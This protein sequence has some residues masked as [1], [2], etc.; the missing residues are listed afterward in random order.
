MCG[1]D[2][3]GGVG[4][5]D[6]QPSCE[7]L[8]ERT[9]LNSVNPTAL[10]SLKVSEILTIAAQ[11]PTGPLAAMRQSGVILGAI[12][13]PSAARILECIQDGHV[14]VAEV[15]SINGGQIVVLVRHQ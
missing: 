1:G 9:T 11:S 15:I 6:S 12:T 10:T 3:G 5:N 13:S 7:S 8:R 2:G 4:P 14:Y